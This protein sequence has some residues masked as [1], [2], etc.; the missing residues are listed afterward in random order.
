MAMEK[1]IP[2]TLRIVGVAA[3]AATL[4]SGLAAAQMTTTKVSGSSGGTGKITR[5]IID[6]VPF[7]S[8]RFSAQATR[9]V[10]CT[11]TGASVS[12]NQ[13]GRR[14]RDSCNVQIG[15]FGYVAAFCPPTDSSQIMLTKSSGSYTYTDVNTIP[16]VTLTEVSPCPSVS[17]IGLLLLVA[18]L[19]GLGLWRLRR[20]RTA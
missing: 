15:S 5:T 14:F 10:T 11:I 20:A 4:W 6:V 19:I 2:R 13:I 9:I 8:Q 18:G 1:P 17:V 7:E 3:L 12:S 16:G